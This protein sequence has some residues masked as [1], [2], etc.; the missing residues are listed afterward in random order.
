MSFHFQPQAD[1][2]DEEA[3]VDISAWKSGAAKPAQD[4]PPSPPTAALEIMDEL[5][6]QLG[7]EDDDDEEEEEIGTF[8]GDL[9]G[10]AE[11]AANGD[12]SEEEVEEVPFV[13]SG[14]TSVNKPARKQVAI[15]LP[16]SSEDE[17][18][19][20]TQVKLPSRAKR[21]TAKP[22]AAQNKAA[23][24]ARVLVPVI[25]RL[26]LDSSEADEIIDFTP[27]N[28]VVRRVKKEI[29]KKR[30]VS[31]YQV[32]F[33]DRHVEEV[34]LSVFCP[35]TRANCVSTILQQHRSASLA[36]QWYHTWS[37]NDFL[38]HAST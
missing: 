21:G 11:P 25:P 8:Q 2:S 24:T 34:S 12:E 13:S 38:S 32:E 36:G 17:Q 10:T 31:V 3:A 28:D 18:P 4:R 20:P 22:N 23:A 14:F 6:G 26:D 35:A 29:K 16:D 19:T 37:W 7:E 27:G 5:A 30:G 9:D 33:E 15:A 1:S